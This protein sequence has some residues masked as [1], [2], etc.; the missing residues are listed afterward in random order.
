MA[1]SPP[2]S[3]RKRPLFVRSPPVSPVSTTPVVCDQSTSELLAASAPLYAMI[4]KTAFSQQ[5][6]SSGDLKASVI[7][8]IRSRMASAVPKTVPQLMSSACPKT[9]Q[10]EWLPLGWARGGM[11]PIRPSLCNDAGI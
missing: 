5:L 6:C 2:S 1:N 9:F 11:R 3:L 4:W 7:R 8:R 10:Y